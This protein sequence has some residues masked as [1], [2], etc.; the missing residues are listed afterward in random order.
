MAQIPYFTFEHKS[1]KIY[2]CADVMIA[3]EQNLVKNVK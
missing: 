3:K 1:L 2:C